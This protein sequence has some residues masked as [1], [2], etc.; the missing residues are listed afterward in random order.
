[1]LSDLEIAQQAELRPI[2]DV[3]SD[4]GIQREELKLYGDHIAKVDLSILDRLEGL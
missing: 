1:M 4:A 2:V 3:A